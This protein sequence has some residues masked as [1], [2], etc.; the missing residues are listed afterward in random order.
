MLEEK[1][2]ELIEEAEVLATQLTPQAIELGKSIAVIEGIDNLVC[3]VAFASASFICFKVVKAFIKR[4]EENHSAQEECAIG[5]IASGFVG[6]I[7]AIPA[8]Y[9]LFNVW[10]YV[11]IINPVLYI[12][13][14]VIL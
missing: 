9:Q 6:V 13:H 11:A 7:T 12:A 4:G 8:L 10:N 1:L 2:V 14:K 5:A 3:G